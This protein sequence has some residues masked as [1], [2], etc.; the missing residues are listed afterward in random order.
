MPLTK[1]QIAVCKVANQLMAMA[2]CSP[3]NSRMGEWAVQCLRY[4]EE[5]D[6]LARFGR[7]AIADLNACEVRTDYSNS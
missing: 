7:D 1:D 4:L 3:P 5:G 2:I 6:E